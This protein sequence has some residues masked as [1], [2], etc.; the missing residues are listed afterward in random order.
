MMVGS[1]IDQRLSSHHWDNY[2]HRRTTKR[3]PCCPTGSY[4]CSCLLPRASTQLRATNGAASSLSERTEQQS[5]QSLVPIQV[6]L[7]VRSSACSQPKEPQ[8]RCLR[9]FAVKSRTGSI[10]ARKPETHFGSLRLRKAAL[11][12]KEA[13]GNAHAL[14][15]RLNRLQ[16]CST[17]P[18][19]SHAASISL[20]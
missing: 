5:W 14:F 12:G 16:I 6:T 10:I 1:R 3:G 4:L 8:T 11:G 20:C 17:S 18:P 13:W 7:C 15:P 9:T 19:S 2:R